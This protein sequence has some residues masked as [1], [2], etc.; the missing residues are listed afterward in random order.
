[1]FVHVQVFTSIT[2]YIHS[3]NN[4]LRSVISQ[5]TKAH[6]QQR[7]ILCNSSEISKKEKTI[8]VDGRHMMKLQ[9]QRRHAGN[10]DTEK[11]A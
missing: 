10:S 3:L 4:D 2:T 9:N 11:L 8:P 7:G 5:R 6:R 1:M